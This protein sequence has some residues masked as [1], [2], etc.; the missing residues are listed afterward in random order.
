[1]NTVYHLADMTDNAETIGIGFQQGTGSSGLYA[2]ALDTGE[3]TG[4]SG[5][6]VPNGLLISGGQQL[7]TSA[8]A[9]SP[10]ANET[11]VSLAMVPENT[12]PAP[13]VVSPGRPIMV[14]V[15]AANPG[16]ILTVSNFTLT[17]NG[18]AIPSRIIVPAA[19]LTGSSSGV[20]A[21]PNGLLPPGIA[22]L[23]PLAPLTSNTT[24]TVTFSG[25][26]DGAPI[27]TTWNFN[28]GN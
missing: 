12:N 16:D 2:C 17:A 7:P 27:N 20:T 22:F 8:V 13:D 25:A 14:R 5:N 19:A 15:N 9:H 6:P 23:L 18:T 4:V 11:A 24:Y 28:T 10:L 1:V 26:R 3:T 21:D